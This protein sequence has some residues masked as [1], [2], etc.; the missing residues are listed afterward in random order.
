MSMTP[1]ELITIDDVTPYPIRQPLPRE[2]GSPGVRLL[3]TTEQPYAW[4]IVSRQVAGWGCLATGEMP[5]APDT[6][7]VLASLSERFGPG[8]DYLPREQFALT[9]PD[10]L[11]IHVRR[12]VDEPYTYCGT[13][14]PNPYV[15]VPRRY[16]Q[17]CMKCTTTYCA[18]NFG[19][20]PF[21]ER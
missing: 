15:H 2:E 5:D 17:H 14:A 1:G 12:K 13:T 20:H 16:Y 9:G 8:H 11:D 7:T 4:A 19:R 6:D 3:I 21:E 18:E 10:K